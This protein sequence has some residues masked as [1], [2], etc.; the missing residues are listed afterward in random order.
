M[1]RWVVGNVLPF[2]MSIGWD[3]YDE[4]WK[5]YALVKLQL[6]FQLSKNRNFCIL[7]LFEPY[8]ENHDQV[9]IKWC[10]WLQ[11]RCWPKI[12]T[13]DCQMTILPLQLIVEQLRFLAV[14]LDLVSLETWHVG[15]WQC[16]W[17]YGTLLSPWKP[18][19]PCKNQNPN[20]STVNCR[21][22]M[23]IWQS[24]VKKF[25]QHLILIPQTSFDQLLIMILKV[26][27]KKT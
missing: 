15:A 6:T 27:L 11:K 12:L 20:C 13:F 8:F 16:V 26:W 5:S 25:G 23:V 18:Q 17:A 21:G 3:F 14:Q 2:K 19:L 1:W 4:T 9:L 10:L 7:R 22:K 24:K